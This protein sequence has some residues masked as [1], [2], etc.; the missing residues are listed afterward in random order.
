MAIIDGFDVLA[1]NEHVTIRC[2]IRAP[3]RSTEL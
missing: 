2:R 3:N 1:A